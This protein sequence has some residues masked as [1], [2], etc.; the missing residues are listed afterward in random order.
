LPEK[1]QTLAFRQLTK[2]HVAAL[3]LSGGRIGATVRG[4]PVLILHH[5]GRRSGQER[6][7]PLLYLPD[8]ERMVIVASKGGSHRHPA[9]FLNL[10]EMEEAE[11]EVGGKTKPVSVRIAAPEERDALWPRV[12]EV[13]PDYAAYQKRT[14]REI[15]LIV[16]EPL[17]AV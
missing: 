6:V 4:A 7:C 11:V 9:W 13:W 5:R 2:V 15:P 1:L 8:G 14:E 16:L 3:R 17:P 12:V 10:R